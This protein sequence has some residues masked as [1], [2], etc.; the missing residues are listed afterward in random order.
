VI[1]L[2]ERGSLSQGGIVLSSSNIALTH[3]EGTS[4]FFFFLVFFLEWLIIEHGQ[5][6][7]LAEMMLR[8]TWRTEV[9]EQCEQIQKTFC[10]LAR[11]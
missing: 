6:A 3:I 7:C 1:L 11:N 8:R 5:L 9:A 4:S 2:F 10:I